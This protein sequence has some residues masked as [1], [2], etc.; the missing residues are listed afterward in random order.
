M[1]ATFQTYLQGTKDIRRVSVAVGAAEVNTDIL[2]PLM[3][4]GSIEGS[5]MGVLALTYPEG[6]P[7]PIECAPINTND[8]VC[9]TRI[10]PS[11]TASVNAIFKSISRSDGGTRF[12][13]QPMTLTQP[14]GP[15]TSTD[16]PIFYGHP[17]DLIVISVDVECTLVL[18]VGLI[19]RFGAGWQ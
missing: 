8:Q 11:D 15:D 2:I 16:S 12:A 5:L 19:D 13:S 10:I 4:A 6:S 14:A 3:P 7:A 17:G 1:V 18:D 9:I